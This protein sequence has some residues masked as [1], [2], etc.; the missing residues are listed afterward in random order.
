M[1]RPSDESARRA[2]EAVFAAAFPFGAEEWVP[3]AAVRRRAALAHVSEHHFRRAR[4]SLGIVTKRYGP[5]GPWWWLPEAAYRLTST[6]PDDHVVFTLREFHEGADAHAR[7]H[8]QRVR[9]ARGVPAVPGTT[10]GLAA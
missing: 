9:D 3:A 1:G 10:M 7:R 2:A 5:C 6:L 8:R 4:R